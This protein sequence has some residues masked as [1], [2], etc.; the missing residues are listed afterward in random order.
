MMKEEQGPGTPPCPPPPFDMALGDTFQAINMEIRD[1]SREIEREPIKFPETAASTSGRSRGQCVRSAPILV[2]TPKVARSDSTAVR[3]MGAPTSKDRSSSGHHKRFRA[4]IENLL[5]D[6][7]EML[8]RVNQLWKPEHG[9]VPERLAETAVMLGQDF[10]AKSGHRERKFGVVTV[11]SK[12]TS[13][14]DAR[15]Q[16][17]ICKQRVQSGRSRPA[18]I[19]KT[20]STTSRP[21]SIGL[22]PL[23]RK[24]R[25][26]SATSNS[27]SY[28]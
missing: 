5:E 12:A 14:Q 23:A 24:V 15:S 11:D 7:I 6:S 25:A 28:H 26:G 13:V 8:T 19:V 1:R 4:T 3:F 9:T 18:K 20:K 2:P 16:T 27:V 21:R 22:A 17:R 10:L